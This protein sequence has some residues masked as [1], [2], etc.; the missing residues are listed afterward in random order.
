MM[1][2]IVTVQAGDRKHPQPSDPKSYPSR[3]DGKPAQIDPRAVDPESGRLLYPDIREDRGEGRNSAP[4]WVGDHTR[5]Y[6]AWAQ[7]ELLTLQTL[8]PVSPD[9]V[10]L[11][12]AMSAGL[13]R[14]W[15]SKSL[16]LGFDFGGGYYVTNFPP[17]PTSINGI[18]ILDGPFKEENPVGIFFDG[19]VDDPFLQ[20]FGF[21]P[22]TLKAG[23]S[24]NGYLLRTSPA[25]NVID[26]RVW[27]R[28]A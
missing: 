9:D 13:I 26:S 22:M 6:N 16:Y 19:K 12:V 27:W 23:R 17:A 4:D 24:G 15:E 28:V 10:S 7:D 21:Q 5:Y 20:L 3:Y 11:W 8:A 18:G 25:V 1:K 14:R 2:I